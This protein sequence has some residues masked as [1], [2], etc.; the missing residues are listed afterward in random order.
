MFG[1]DTNTHIQ[2]S[3]IQNYKSAIRWRLNAHTYILILKIWVYNGIKFTACGMLQCYYMLPPSLSP[4]AN[5]TTTNAPPAAHKCVERSLKRT[6]KTV[7]MNSVHLVLRLLTKTAEIV[8]AAAAAEDFGEKLNITMEGTCTH[9]Q[10]QHNVSA[11][12]I[13]HTHTQNEFNKSKFSL[14]WKPKKKERT[15]RQYASTREVR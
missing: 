3:H 13:L 2:H 10:S 11:N 7:T 15:W 12:R 9:T 6:S 5:R 14:K 8:G 4:K 1:N